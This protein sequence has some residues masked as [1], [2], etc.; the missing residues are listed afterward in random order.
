[1]SQLEIGS[2]G[3]NEDEDAYDDDDYAYDDAGFDDFAPAVAKGGGG[4]RAAKKKHATV[5]AAPPPPPTHAQPA[6][7]LAPAHVV[8]RRLQSLPAALQTRC[9]V[10]YDDRFAG[11]LF[12]TVPRFASAADGPAHGGAPASTGVAIPLHRVTMFRVR[13]RVVWDRDTRLDLLTPAAA[14]PFDLMASALLSEADFAAEV[15]QRLSNLA[16]GLAS[17][18]IRPVAAP[19]GN[20]SISSRLTLSPRCELLKAD[21]VAVVVATFADEAA[22]VLATVGRDDGDFDRYLGFVDKAVSA[23]TR[24]GVLFAATDADT[25]ACAAASGGDGSLRLAVQSAELDG[26][27][28]AV[29]TVRLAQ[30]SVIALCELQCALEVALSATT[31]PARTLIARH[32]SVRL[33]LADE[34]AARALAAADEGNVTVV[35]RGFRLMAPARLVPAGVFDAGPE[36][37]ACHQL[38]AA[39]NVDGTLNPTVHRQL[40]ATVRECGPS[41]RPLPAY[42]PAD[43][44]EAWL[45][46]RHTSPEDAATGSAITAAA[47][48]TTFISQR[49]GVYAVAGD[50]YGGD[51]MMRQWLA[52]IEHSSRT[53]FFVEE[54]RRAD[55]FRFYLDVDLP[56]STPPTAVVGGLSEADECAFTRDLLTTLWRLCCDAAAPGGALA[57]ELYADAVADRSAPPR[58]IVAFRC[59]GAYDDA[60]P[61]QLPVASKLGLRLY[62]PGSVTSAARYPAQVSRLAELLTAGGGPL[63]VPAALEAAVVRRDAGRASFWHE[64]LDADHAGWDRGRLIGTTKRR[65]V[66]HFDRRYR[67]LATAMGAPNDS[68]CAAANATS[69]VEVRPL[70]PSFSAELLRKTLLR[71]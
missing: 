17:S 5:A 19:T 29:V 32:S 41:G 20:A 60:S 16:A 45:A 43:A 49:G 36:Q 18:Q 44:L 3:W 51:A 63:L 68:A 37:Q 6:T 64:A 26:A 69:A 27:D 66:Q 25:S 39:F 56:L 1:M 71:A 48:T 59:F 53:P 33:R 65:R 9:E 4:K 12:T 31:S 30:A 14:Q 8:L 24:F 22:S 34:G 42:V 58:E 50:A 21:G 61:A 47:S 40:A 2:S 62:F 35:V 55:R 7:T 13:G 28:P 38:V 54:V 70:P 52:A 23:A 67:P 10:G 46:A 11:T 57:R 15:D